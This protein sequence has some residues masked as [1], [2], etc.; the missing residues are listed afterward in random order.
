MSDLGDFADHDRDEAGSGATDAGD[1]ED[2][3]QRADL[4][5]VGDDAG[6]GALAVSEGLRIHEDGQETALKAYVTAGN[7]SAV[8]LGTYLVAPY[9]RGEKLFCKITG[10]EYVQAFQSDD[11][12]E[13][14]ARR[15]MRSD[16]VDEQDYKFLAELDPVAVLYS[17][18]GDLKRRMP[19]RVPKPETIVRAADDATEIKTGLKIPEDGVF[20]GHLSVGGEKV[21]TA[22]EPPTIDYRVKDDYESGDPSSSGTRSLPAAPAPGRPTPRRTS[23]G[24]T[25]TGTAATPSTRAVRSAGWR[26]S[27]STRRTSTPRCTTTTPGPT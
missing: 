1:D 16:G 10:L 23:C 14:H 25:S 13:I 15:A 5:D 22:A 4:D 24:S 12:T 7:R 9:P 11:A 19:D 6:L 2:D 26:S 3:F 27:S 8:R 21:R 18:Q 20:L 17:D